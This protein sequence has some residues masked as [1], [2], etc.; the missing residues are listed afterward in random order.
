MQAIKRLNKRQSY[1][2]PSL[3]A[4]VLQRRPA[5]FGFESFRLTLTSIEFLPALKNVVHH[6]SWVTPERSRLV[7]HL[8]CRSKTIYL[9]FGDAE[10]TSSPRWL[11][12]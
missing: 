7:M 10:I 6:A 1:N 12:F 2:I 11:Q 4:R 8:I 9:D 5:Q 3:E